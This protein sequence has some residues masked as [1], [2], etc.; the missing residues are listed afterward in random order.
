MTLEKNQSPIRYPINFIDD[1]PEPYTTGR[2]RTTDLREILNAIFYLNK[3]G[4]PWRYL[5]TAE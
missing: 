5:P 4:C 1:E 2:P 3:A